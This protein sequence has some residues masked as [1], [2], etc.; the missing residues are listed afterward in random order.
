MSSAIGARH[1]IAS[2]TRR[3]ARKFSAARLAYG[4]GTFN[5]TEEAAWLVLHS[6]K[7]PLDRFEENARRP[8]SP[9]ELVLIDKLSERRIRD[10]IP[11]AYLTHEAWLGDHS[12]YVDRRVIVP[13]S[14]IAELLPDG[15]APFL[16]VP[17]RSALDMCTGS[18]C[19]AVL[20]AR[21]FPRARVDGVDLSSGALTV[22][23]RNVAAYRLEKRIRL[24]QSNLF[25]A[26]PAQRYDLIVSNPPY[27]DA[28]SMASLPDEYR[29]EPRMAL[30]GGEDGLVLVHR[31]LAAMKLHLNPGGSLVCEIGHNRK[32]LERAYPRM[33]FTWLD[34]SAGDGYVFLIGREQLPG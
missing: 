30:A 28:K 24:K 20:L 11:V 18:G 32:A 15:I 6:C 26:I 8:V 7:V 4:H 22:A 16:Q 13:R 9:S 2:V 25:H 27:V 29:S 33:P 34:T 31:I 14:F 17:V 12:F 3:I 10:R 1:S 5:A 23:K 19:L 21:A